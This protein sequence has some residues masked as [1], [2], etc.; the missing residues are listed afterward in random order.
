MKGILSIFGGSALL[1]FVLAFPPG[2]AASPADNQLFQDKTTSIFDAKAIDND[3]AAGPAVVK[4]ATGSRTWAPTDAVANTQR[5]LVGPR[6]V[7]G[8]LTVVPAYR[9]IDPG[10]RN[11]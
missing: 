7:G 5:L 10:R 11:A 2:V 3:A 9:H 4:L 1:A 8:S 6:I